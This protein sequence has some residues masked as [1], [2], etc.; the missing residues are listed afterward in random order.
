MQGDDE[1]I[2]KVMMEEYHV[3]FPVYPETCGIWMIRCGAKYGKKEQSYCH[4]LHER[5]DVVAYREKYIAR[6][7]GTLANPSLR[8]LSQYSD[9]QSEGGRVREDAH[10]PGG[11]SAPYGG[12]VHVYA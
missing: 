2:A 5:P 3:K 10:G 6:D 8:E 9:D 11:R 4:D 1:A 12:R 7:M